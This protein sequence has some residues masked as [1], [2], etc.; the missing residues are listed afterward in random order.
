MFGRLIRFAAA[1]AVVVF[2][3]STLLAASPEGAGKGQAA[4]DAAAQAN[5]F[6]FLLFYK[7]N[8]AA[9]QSAA[10]VL[11]QGV[12]KRSARAAYSFVNV[13]DLAEQPLVKQFDVARTAM[14]FMLAVAPNG[15]ITCVYPKPFEDAELDLAFVTPAMTRV[16]KQIQGGKVVLLCA[17][18]AS[19]TTYPVGVTQFTSDPL[20]SQ[21]SAV[22]PLRMDDPAEA[23]FLTD[24]KIDA[25][26]TDTTIVFLAPPGVMVGK[27]PSTVTK[28]QL[29]TEL[30]AA[31]KCCNDPNCKH[32]H[33]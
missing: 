12:T 23:R 21:R 10:K 20:F 9:T 18:P 31:G 28:A 25:R 30:H 3:S 13:A 22:V 26:A 15:A 29:A 32:G 24:L 5:K 14:P 2:A 1:L 8:D 17:H 16:M 19:A 6:C 11:S 33:K 4:L 27:F 7:T